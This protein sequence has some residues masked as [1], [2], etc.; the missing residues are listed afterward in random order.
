MPIG[1]YVH[2]PFCRNRCAYC[3]FY[4]ELHDPGLEQ[5][6]YDALAIETELVAA[7]S[8]G[9]RVDIGTIYVGGGT[10]SL[11]NIDLFAR[12]LDQARDLFSFAAEP[13]FSI[14]HNPETVTREK[15]AALRDLGCNR[16]VFGVQSFDQRLLKL[17]GRRHRPRSSH[18]AVYLANA[19]GF[20][21][22]GLDLMFGLPGQTSK[23][24]SA[25][26]DH[27]L[28][29]EP[30]H[31]SFYQL[32]IEEGTR[33]AEQVKAGKVKPVDAELLLAMYR[34]GCEQ[35]ADEGYVRYEVSSFARPGFECR[36]NLGYWEGGD[37]IG[38]GPSAH[39]FV[40]NERY[41]NIADLAGYVESLKSGRRPLIEDRSGVEQRMMEAIMLG[42]RTARGINRRQFAA[43][44]GRPLDDRLDRK[45]YELFIQSGHLIPD[46]GR[47]RLSDEGI[48]L[49]DEITR[50]LL[51]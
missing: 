7:S 38:L 4:K 11:T 46:R 20:E 19:L 42:L 48:C 39:S 10:P 43:R 35:M 6:F 14:E 13:E 51:K 41:S 47:L 18:K 12:W 24:L 15:L 45:Q 9:R 17:L 37:Y 50:R 44:F 3:D 5:H 27:L 40:G 26:L 32:T 16:P 25:D 36:H 49:A 30:P 21:N 22:F 29:L 34:G 28:D 31:I 33:L 2:F 1:L 8:A 23:M